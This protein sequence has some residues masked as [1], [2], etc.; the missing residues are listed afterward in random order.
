[1]HCVYFFL[2]CTI[3]II[4]SISVFSFVQ[5]FPPHL[6]SVKNCIFQI[7]MSSKK[8]VLRLFLSSQNRSHP[9]DIKH[10]HLSFLSIQSFKRSFFRL[11]PSKSFHTPNHNKIDTIIRLNIKVY[12]LTDC[13]EFISTPIG[14]VEIIPE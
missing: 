14:N 9:E 3:L 8:Y 10:R 11:S 4:S 12:L 7:I 5:A 6:L 1:M 2:I 13:D